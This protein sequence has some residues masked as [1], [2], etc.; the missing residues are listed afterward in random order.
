MIP[1]V[2]ICRSHA[3]LALMTD[4]EDRRGPAN[5]H[6][7][8]LAPRTRESKVA[9]RHVDPCLTFPRTNGQ[10]ISRRQFTLT[11]VPGSYTT[12]GC[13]PICIIREGHSP[14][15]HAR[16]VNCELARVCCAIA[17]RGRIYTYGIVQGPPWRE[18]SSEKLDSIVPS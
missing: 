2:R 15:T 9:H 8:I 3:L 10:A 4:P 6:P 14:R 18:A 17:Q 5:H 1:L 12:G 13:Q 11:S 16:C 7:G